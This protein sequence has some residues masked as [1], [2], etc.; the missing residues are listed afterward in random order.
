MSWRPIDQPPQPPDRPHTAM[1]RCTDDEG[2]YLLPGPVMWDTVRRQWQR[3]SGEPVRLHP[4][5]Q[6]HW[7]DEADILTPLP[8]CAAQ[9]QQTQPSTTGCDRCRN[10]LFAGRTCDACGR[11]NW[12]DEDA[13]SVVSAG[14]PKE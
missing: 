1:I 7:R 11:L 8:E 6:Y 3:E 13:A 12:G 4:G 2:E 5:A 10:P 9:E 14:L